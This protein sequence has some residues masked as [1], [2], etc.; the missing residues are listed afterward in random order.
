MY[1]LYMWPIC[2]CMYIVHVD[3]HPYKYIIHTYQ[4][5]GDG[6]QFTAE[7]VAQERETFRLVVCQHSLEG[8]APEPHTQVPRDSEGRDIAT[9]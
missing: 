3:I 9:L 8:V 2:T 7:E 6:V 5:I 4:G 1:M